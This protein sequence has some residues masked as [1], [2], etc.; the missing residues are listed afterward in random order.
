MVPIQA[1]NATEE[2]NSTTNRGREIF[3]E[4]KNVLF[5]VE[6]ATLKFSNFFFAHMAMQI[7]TFSKIKYF[8]VTTFKHCIVK[9]LS[10]SLM[11]HA[12]LSS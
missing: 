10:G 12:K 9:L 8:H 4:L 5:T 2:K 7:F 1:K 6:H 3:N 11:S